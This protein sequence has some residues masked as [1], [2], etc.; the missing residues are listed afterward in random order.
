MSHCLVGCHTPIT[1]CSAFFLGT[2]TVFKIKK[3]KNPLHVVHRLLKGIFNLLHSA[4]FG[5]LLKIQIP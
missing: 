3:K 4:I 2:Q 5:S 1:L